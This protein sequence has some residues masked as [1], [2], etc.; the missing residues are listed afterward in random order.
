MTMFCIISL[1]DPDLVLGYEGSVLLFETVE[2]AQDFCD[3]TA[4]EDNQFGVIEAPFAVLQRDA[5][6]VV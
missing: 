1:D 6:V 3:F 2:A 4:T 5:V